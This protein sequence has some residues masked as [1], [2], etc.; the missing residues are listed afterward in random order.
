VAEERADMP[1]DDLKK[2]DATFNT[3]KDPI[4]SMKSRLVK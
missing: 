3:V 1:A 2:L 4:L